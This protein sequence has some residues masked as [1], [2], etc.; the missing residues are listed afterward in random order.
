MG[1]LQ[2]I[3]G[4]VATTHSTRDEEV[5]T[6]THAELTREQAEALG[7][8]IAEQGAHL[9]AATHRL[10]ADLR[11]FDQSRAWASQGAL[12]CAH[13]LSWR[14]GWSGG[15]AREHVRVANRLGDLPAIDEALR[16]GE[17]SY[18]KVRAMTRVATPANE[19][20][21]LD[22]ARHCTGNQLEKVC[23][24]YAMVQRS[25]G[26]APIDD[27]KR[28]YVSKRDLEDGM[29]GIDMVLEPVEAATIW[30]AL[31]VVARE[32]SKA[33]PFNRV[34]ALREI[35]EAVLRG[36]KPDRSPT[37]LVVTIAAEVLDGSDPTALQVATLSDGTCVSA[38]T[39]RRL[40]CDCGVVTIHE[41]SHG[42]PLSVGRK[43]RSIGA[44][45]LR[46]MRE[47]DQ[48]CRFPGCSHR[49]FV[50]GHHLEHWA[51]GGETKLEN[52]LSL[53][54]FHH[55]F[56]HEYGYRVELDDQQ[57]PHF[58]DPHGRPVREVPPRPVTAALGAASIR[59]ANEA[60]AITPATNEPRWDG[61]SPDYSLIVDDLVIADRE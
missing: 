18:C 35:C 56:V 13:W 57:Q 19:Q 38:E 9:D 10:L 22:D 50:H 42:T 37:E 23:H 59:R 54:A 1:S 20:L 40:A 51:K 55:I 6:S 58:F 4:V 25:V 2:T 32:R 29:V 36:D 5:A 61:E 43:T 39:A 44:A 11:R 34:D 7:E 41:D 60:L 21:L 8:Q 17:V 30:E 48:T 33:G 45:I 28:R 27:D 15:R 26:R 49:Q 46:A 16:Q 31:S 12:T 14:L 3:N 47:R 52:L 53:C 24:K